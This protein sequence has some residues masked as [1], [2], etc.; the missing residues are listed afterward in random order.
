[1]TTGERRMTKTKTISRGGGTKT[2]SKIVTTGD[3][4]SKTTSEE[5]DGTTTTTGIRRTATTEDGRGR[6]NDDD[7]MTGKEE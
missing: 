2:R 1:M 5:E 4:G 6:M 7:G 3:R